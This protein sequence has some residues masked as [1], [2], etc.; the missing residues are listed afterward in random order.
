MAIQTQSISNMMKVESGAK[1]A[2]S[3]IL[4]S[5]MDTA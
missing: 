5:T 2:P 4:S 3:T 1:Q